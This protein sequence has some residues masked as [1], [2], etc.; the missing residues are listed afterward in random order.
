MP[1]CLV[2]L[3]G[4]MFSGIIC[5][6]VDAT[7][8]ETE[9]LTLCVA[10]FEPMEALIYR[11]GSFWCHGAHGESLSS[12]VVGGDHGAFELWMAHFF[13]HCEDGNREFAS[14]T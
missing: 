5:T 1:D 8:P 4:M 3:R 2:M 14:V 7:M 12:N 6:V 13:E 10:A 9:E 11:F